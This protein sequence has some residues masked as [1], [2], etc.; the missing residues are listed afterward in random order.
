MDR[1]PGFFGRLRRVHDVA[2]ALVIT[3]VTQV[4]IWAGSV[5]TPLDDR[6]VAA[7]LALV[8]TAPVMVRRR[9]PLLTLL[10]VFLPLWVLTAQRS[11]Q[12]T[13]GYLLAMM[14]ATYSVAAHASVRGALVGLAVAMLSAEGNSLAMPDPEPGDFFFPMLLLGIPWAAGRALRV[15]RARAAELARLNEELAAEREASARLAVEAERG[16]IAR[17]LHDTLV[18][19]LNIVVVH[20][21]A[22]EEA[23]NSDPGTSRESLHRIQEVGRSALDQV[24]EMLGMLRA[25]G[26][27][28]R[29]ARISGLD[30]LCEDLRAAGVA[31]DLVREGD[32]D[33]LSEQEQVTVFRIVQESLINVRK[34]AGARRVTVGIRG[35][36][37]DVEVTVSDDGI[38]TT[39][40]TSG[41]GGYG[42]VGMRERV[43][44]L[45]GRL[46]ISA[47]P[48]GG[49]VVHA[50]LPRK[51]RVS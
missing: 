26:S 24:R 45:G 5:A 39:Q 36:D 30:A 13:I 25:H 15:W 21:E 19:S 37:Q 9:W 27:V 14:V 51:A 4:E 40:Q 38:G 28:T 48:H 16:N 35:G 50:V 8:G 17:D 7:A 6:P 1:A 33:R 2:L 3:T 42:I 10:A 47:G 18:Q 46:T 20:A 31:V 12:F 11:D 34:H 41:R 23:L 29:P 32:L 49:Q 43:G 22:A 44:L